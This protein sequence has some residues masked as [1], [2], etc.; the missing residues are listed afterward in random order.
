MKSLIATSIFC[1][2]VSVT[3]TVAAQSPGMDQ[4]PGWGPGPGSGMGP[5]PGMGRGMGA[6]IPLFVDFDLDKNGY[7]DESEF[8]EARGARVSERAKEGGQMLG[9]SNMMQFSELDLNADGKVTP[10]EFTQGEAAHRRKK[11]SQ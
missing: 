10:G 2:L 4:K 3:L 5:G 7:L 8:I 11:L 9:L 6:N 1:L